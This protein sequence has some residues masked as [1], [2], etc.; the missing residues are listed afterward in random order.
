M[1]KF[2]LRIW[3]S[4]WGMLDVLMTLLSWS[5]IVCLMLRVQIA[6]DAM[7]QLRVA[8]F[9][10]FVNLKG[11]TTWDGVSSFL[12]MLFITCTSLY[13][14]M[15]YYYVIFKIAFQ[16]LEALI[17]CMLTVH[18]LRCLSLVKYLPRSYRLG[19]VLASAWNDVKII[20]FV[21]YV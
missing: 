5:Y 4:Y 11:L 16:V 15:A 14:F 21:N 6:E 3:K 19:L 10:K 13:I 8:Y 1:I 17:G 12:I 18:L 2:F 7:W 20:R 9:Q